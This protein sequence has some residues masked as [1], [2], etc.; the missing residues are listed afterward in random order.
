MRP[1][2]RSRGTPGLPRAAKSRPKASP[3]HPRGSLRAS[4]TA[5]KIILRC[6]QQR[7]SPQTHSEGRVDRF[8][9]DFKSM[10]RNSE[11]CFVL[12][13]KTFFRCRT[14]FASRALRTQ[15]TRKNFRF[16][17][18]NRDFGRPGDVRMST[19]ERPN[20]QVERKSA[21]EVLPGLPKIQK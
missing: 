9:I 3:G 8:L 4:G 10:R 15:K 20:G 19:F 5:P 6:S 7:S 1:Q 18:E 16:G 21:L 13:F 14:L 2:S 12:V 17:L 11:V